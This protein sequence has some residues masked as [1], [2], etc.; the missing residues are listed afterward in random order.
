M[1]SQKGTAYV[2]GFE[3]N[4]G[5]GLK[6][7]IFSQQD[8]TVTLAVSV[9]RLTV[10]TV[11][12]DLMQLK[13]N[14]EKIKSS[15]TVK[16]AASDAE[17]KINFIDVTLG[18]V[19]LRAGN[20]V[21]EFN[22]VNAL[23]YNFNL[24]KLRGNEQLR[25]TYS[26]FLFKASEFAMPGAGTGGMPKKE[27]TGFVGNLS[28]NKNATL[29]FKIVAEENCTVVL[30]AAV[31][32]RR[33]GARKFTAGFVPSVEGKEIESD[34]IVPQGEQSTEWTVSYRVTI[35]EVELTKGENTLIFTVPVNVGNTD[36][37][38]FDYIVITSMYNVS[39]IS[40]WE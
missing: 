33:Q 12:T 11:F 13:V 6:F 30:S 24:I 19:S 22:T 29:T 36:A 34:V 23:S 20:N 15:A 39:C 2:G 7:N 8:T 26:S 18:C 9:N 1:V 38:N 40:S 37:S 4:L 25:E 32:G 35:G 31:T 16:A 21:I 3:E 17:Y 28:G 5:A 14:G 27:N 10:D